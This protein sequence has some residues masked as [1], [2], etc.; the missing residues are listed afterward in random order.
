M[1]FFKYE[2]IPNPQYKEFGVHPKYQL[3]ALVVSWGLKSDIE[4][5]NERHGTTL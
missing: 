2:L 1:A 4:A 3:K 5:Y